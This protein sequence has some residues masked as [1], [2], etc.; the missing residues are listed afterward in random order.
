MESSF[1]VRDLRN[2]EWFWI[3]KIVLEQ[4][5]KLV[6]AEGI[7]IYNALCCFANGKTNDCF[8]SLQTLENLTGLSHPTVCKYL[9]LLETHG[10]I[11]IENRQ[12]ENKSNLYTLVKVVNKVVKE[13]NR[14]SKG[15]EQGVVKEINTNNNKYKQELIN[16]KGTLPFLL[17]LYKSQNKEHLR[18]YPKWHSQIEAEIVAALANGWTAKEI[19]E[20]L[21]LVAGKGTP[22]WEIFK[23][24]EVAG[25]WTKLALERRSTNLQKTLD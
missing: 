7:L 4:Y 14:G 12:E 8:P 13:I 15:D 21:Y 11:I 20:Q 16:K 3:H 24:K 1:Q 22:P 10:L 23:K 2:G 17:T 25:K 19:E 9:K 6:G 18:A 5:S